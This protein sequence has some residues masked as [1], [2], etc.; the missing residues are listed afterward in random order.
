MD[1][2]YGI[3]FFLLDLPEGRAENKSRHYRTIM[4]WRFMQFLA[5]T[6]CCS[7]NGYRVFHV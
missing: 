3:Y 7:L 5:K 2:V 4:N 6:Y 1:S